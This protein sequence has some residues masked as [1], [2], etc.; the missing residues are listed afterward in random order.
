MYI[1]FIKQLHNSEA[2]SQDSLLPDFAQKKENT[3]YP[4]LMTKEDASQKNI[5]WFDDLVKLF[6]LGKDLGVIKDLIVHGSFGDF[7]Q[8]NFSDLE[9]SVFVNESVF[10]SLGKKMLLSRWVRHQLN[11][12]ILKVDP[13]QHHGAFFLWEMLISN[14]DERILPVC[15]YETCWSVTGNSLEFQI[16]KNEKIMTEESRRRLTLTLS[17][18]ASPGKHFFRY[19]I[20]N[21]SAKRYLS[22]I[23]LIPAFFYQSQGLKLNKKKAIEKFLKEEIGDFSSALIVA[24]QLRDCWPE[25]SNILRSLRPLLVSESIP[26]GR[27]DILL[28]SMFRQGSVRE[29]VKNDVMPYVFAGANELMSKFL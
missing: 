14:Y 22:N 10:S 11:K 4:F 12:L 29:K 7:T 13:L 23:M 28:S 9:I 3:I 17:N 20:S 25:T 27:A 6:E 19:G 21:Y 26:Q 24:A 8:T 1:D 15:A 5:W 2:W 18:L 16:I